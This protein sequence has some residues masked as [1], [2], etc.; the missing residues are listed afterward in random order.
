M[1][2]VRIPLKK[3]EIRISRD[4]I[5]RTVKEYALISIALLLYSFSWMAILR[6]AMVSSGGVTGVGMMLYY[7]A[8]IP[9]G[10]TLFA[11]NG[12]LVVVAAFIIGLR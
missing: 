4:S 12:V 5:R 6:P 11:V 10:L 1:K 9:V 3:P 2:P 8:D 7:A